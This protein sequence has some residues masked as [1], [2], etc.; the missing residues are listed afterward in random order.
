MG[1]EFF[2]IFNERGNKYYFISAIKQ[3]YVDNNGGRPAARENE[4][5][6]N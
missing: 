1:I 2:I 4:Q 6:E 5:E 3:R